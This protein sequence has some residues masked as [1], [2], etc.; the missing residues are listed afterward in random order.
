M[1]ESGM[2]VRKRLFQH[3]PRI[4]FVWST[5]SGMYDLIIRGTTIMV[6]EYRGLSN[7]VWSTTPSLFEISGKIGYFDQTD[8]A[9]VK[10]A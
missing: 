7:H 4:L 2:F 9:T 6:Q 10:M 1:M 8:H 3:R 5:K